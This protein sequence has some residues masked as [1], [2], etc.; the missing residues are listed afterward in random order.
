MVGAIDWAWWSHMTHLCGTSLELMSTALDMLS[1]VFARPRH[2]IGRPEG[3]GVETDVGGFW[4][5][6]AARA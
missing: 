4:P 3:V 2:C 6:S 1:V 5:D